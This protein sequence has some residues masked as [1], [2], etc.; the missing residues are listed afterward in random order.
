MLTSLK[1]E[2]TLAAGMSLGNC[3]TELSVCNYSVAMESAGSFPENLK[4]GE[5]VG[6]KTATPKLIYKDSNM[7]LVT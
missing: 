5:T 1:E 4:E 2:D 7:E 3:F 6:W